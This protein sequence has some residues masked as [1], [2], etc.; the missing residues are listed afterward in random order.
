[1]TQSGP[2]AVLRRTGHGPGPRRETAVRGLPEGYVPC[3]PGGATSR[4]RRRLRPG[5]ARRGLCPGA[6]VGLRLA[7]RERLPQTRQG[8]AGRA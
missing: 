7:S 1:M 3:L 6:L 2:G 5:A 8:L 4:A